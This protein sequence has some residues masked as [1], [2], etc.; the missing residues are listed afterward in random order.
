[1]PASRPAPQGTA[2]TAAA[3]TP[4]PPPAPAPG[5]SSS[6]DVVGW[7]AFSCV[8]V[9]VVL[10]VY[11]TSLGGAVGAAL[12]LVAV[13]GVCRILLRRSERSAASLLA[14]QNAKRR[15]ADGASGAHARRGDRRAA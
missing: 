5:R 15:E 13:T 8:L 2:A 7:A 4:A 6:S 12:G 3:P 1:M 9:P 11:G 14:E 10:V